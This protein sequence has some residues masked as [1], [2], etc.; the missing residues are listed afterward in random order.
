SL[1]LR[2]SEPKFQDIPTKL[3]E[4]PSWMTPLDESSIS[5]RTPKIFRLIALD[6]RVAS[7]SRIPSVPAAPP[8]NQSNADRN[9]PAGTRNAYGFAAFNALSFQMVLGS[10]MILYA[11]SLG[12]SAT[13]L[14]LIAGMLPLLVALQIPAA[15]YV[16]R[17]GYKVF[18]V[19]G[20]TIRTFFV[21]LM[22]P[23][24][25]AMVPLSNDARLLAMIVLLFCFNGVRGVASCG[26]LPW[27]ATL[28]PPTFRGRYLA[29]EAGVTNIASVVAYG[30]AAVALGRNA[31]PWRFSVLFG[32][33]AIC[34]VA[35]VIF[36]SRIPRE[37]AILSTAVP[38]RPG[39]TDIWRHTAFRKLLVMNVCWSF[40]SGGVLTFVVSF[41][42]EILAM[43][44]RTILILTS[45]TFAGG[46]LNQFL[47]RK[48]LDQYG[49]KPVMTIAL[50]LWIMAM[51]LWAC[52]A[53]SALPAMAAVIVAL[54]VTVG[55]ANSLMNLANTRLAMIVIPD[56]GRSRYFAVFSVVGSVALGL[57]PIL[58]GSLLDA[59]HDTAF[60]VG[61]FNINRYSILFS[62]LAAGFVA[63]LFFTRSLEEPEAED[64]DLI[65]GNAMSN[66]RVR[67]WL[68]F[69]FR[70]TPRS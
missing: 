68:R 36:L 5:S 13:I 30:L 57:S 20:W 9:Y 11:K 1:T 49:S 46:I 21:G 27:I 52:V 32:F 47:L 17:A 34:A 7:L 2:Y 60:L 64:F 43:P 48:A 35:S 19:T 45:L 15:G 56:E 58:W 61:Q 40:A 29:T 42:K 39:Y 70:S 65:V 62:I 33:S 8:Q 67:Y 41:L 26:W 59:L 44:E 53:S 38:G 22:I 24:P 14:G 25:L 37:P 6:D 31:E 4:E 50:V 54:I 12:A 69:W 51:A 63:T 28:I 10:P 16:D 55:L 23:V 66:S 3:P 18:V